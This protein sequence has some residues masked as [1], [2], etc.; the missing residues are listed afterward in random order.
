[1]KTIWKFPVGI[2]QIFELKM[3]SGAKILSVQVQHELPVIWALVD[4]DASPVV[5]TFYV[6]GTGHSSDGLEH[7]D[8]V[9][10]FQM[11]DGIFAFHLFVDRDNSDGNT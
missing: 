3:P 2:T 8:F 11:S 7:A 9:G 6:R 1:M 10:T 4:S 5:R